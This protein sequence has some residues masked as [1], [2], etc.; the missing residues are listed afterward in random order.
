MSNRQHKDYEKNF[1]GGWARN[2]GAIITTMNSSIAMISRIFT[3]ENFKAFFEGFFVIIGLFAKLLWQ[4]W[5]ICLAL[6]II[7]L[8]K[9]WWIKRK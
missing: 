6:I 3:W 5:P 8:I 7:V 9:L 4:A 1:C 2:S